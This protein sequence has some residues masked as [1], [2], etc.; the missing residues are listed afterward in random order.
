MIL[1]ILVIAAHP[2]DEVLGMG[3]TIKKLSKNNKIQLCVVS[4]GTSAQYK[5]KK[6]IEIRKN[7]CIK[8]GKLLGISDFE[9]LDFPDM[10]LDSVPQIEINK[11]LEKVV[12]KHKPKVIYT[13]PQNDLNKDHQQVHNS[14]LVVARP[15]SSTI[16]TILCYELPGYVKHPF[17]PTVY[18]DVSKEFS[19]K[20]RAFKIYKSEIQKNPY[21]RSLKAIKNL[22]IYR[23][24]QSGLEKAE[25][26][27][28]VRSISD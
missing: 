27:Q 5:D 15:L 10:K 11:E 23:G 8:S 2:D 26:F 18:E 3:G 9:F 19:F 1:N 20:I 21:P 14:T 6:M 22:A 16:K 4:E 25:A 12:R 28:L 17:V 13:T 24:T 7:A